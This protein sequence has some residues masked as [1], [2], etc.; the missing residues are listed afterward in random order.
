VHREVEKP[1]LKVEANLNE[2]KLNRKLGKQKYVRNSRLGHEEQ[3]S[4]KLSEFC[5][6][7]IYEHLDSSRLRT[8]TYTC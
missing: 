4:S 6:S 5:L 1:T 2:G 7:F 3:S 8:S